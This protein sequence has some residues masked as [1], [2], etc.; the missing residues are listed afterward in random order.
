MDWT[1]IIA[2]MQKLAELPAGSPLY[3]SIRSGL[4]EQERAF[5]EALEDMIDKQIEQDRESHAED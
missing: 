3:W 4:D 5:V 1:K 2:A